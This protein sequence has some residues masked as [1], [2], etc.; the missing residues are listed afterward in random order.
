MKQKIILISALLTFLF[1][2]L[3]AYAEYDREQV[4]SVMR[5]NVRLLGEAK[6][7][8]GAKDYF[9]AAESLM[10]MARG[11]RSIREFS[12]PK[13]DAGQWRKTID[14]VVNAAFKGIGAAGMRDDAGL[15]AAVA[16]LGRLSGV[17]HGQFR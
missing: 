1:A 9:A 13:G 11:M 4:V 8:A 3:S 12:P 5:A 7:A 16:E 10:E 17:G 6:K 15:A 14:D 2:G